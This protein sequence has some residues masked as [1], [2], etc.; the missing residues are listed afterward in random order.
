MQD[1]KKKMLSLL[2]GSEYLTNS[3]FAVNDILDY[4]KE[5]D[6]VETY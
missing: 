4:V 3:K 1:L 5:I 6:N 2:G